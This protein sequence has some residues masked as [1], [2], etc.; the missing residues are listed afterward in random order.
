VL[1]VDD[2]PDGLELVASIL[3]TAGADAM[4]SASPPEAVALILSWTPH[5]LISDIE[6]PGEDGYS[7][8]RRVRALD[9]AE[10]GRTPAVALTAYG[11][12]EDRVRSLSAGMAEARRSCRVGRDRRQP[13]RPLDRTV[14]ST[15]SALRY[16]VGPLSRVRGWQRCR[17][18]SPDNVAVVAADPVS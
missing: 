8:I 14:A 5:V 11:R 17:A 6:M 16:G 3:R 12:P 15:V 13:R 18:A 1:V 10:G 4:P 9:P 7:R 2:E